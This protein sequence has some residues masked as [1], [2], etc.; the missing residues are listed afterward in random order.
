MPPRV[1]ERLRSSICP[2]WVDGLYGEAAS[3]QYAEIH[4]TLGQVDEAFA[5]LDRGWRIK[6]P[7]LFLMKTDPMLDPI[8]RD[9]RFAALMNKIGF[10][11]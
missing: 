11:A 8:R 5:A 4:A 1:T 7:G 3:Y 10:P 6:D 9:P 2:Q